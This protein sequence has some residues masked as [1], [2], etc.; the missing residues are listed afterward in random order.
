MRLVKRKM[1]HW[2][3]GYIFVAPTII[4][5]IVLNI[6]PIIQTVLLSFQESLGFNRY[7]FAGL[8]NFYSVLSDTD[9]WL[10]LKN[11]FVFALISVPVSIFLSLIFAWLL[12]K[13]IKGTSVYRMIFFLPLVA[14]P[15]AVTMVWSW[16]YNTEF[17]VLNYLLG[18]L[19]I[20][21]ISW[22]NDTRYTMLSLIIIAV[23]GSL[24]QQIIILIVAIK[25]VPKTYYEAAE[26]DG[27][28]DRRKFFNIMI[29]LVSPNIFFLTVT[30]LIGAL[31][32]FDL[33]YMIYGTGNSEALDSVKT[34]MYQY[35]RQSFVVQDKAYGS[36]IAVVTLIIILV[37]T[38]IQMKLQKK[39][40]FYE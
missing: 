37:L 33:V 11:T 10:G 21:K 8:D 4:G 19:G 9:V 39:V 14:A 20:P 40:V 2:A 5:L 32:Q 23:W 13:P 26:I 7:E 12:C 28:T 36:A 3:W 35:Y 30:G 17:G 27:A 6:W 34:I 31:G 1:K 25:N 24:G 38:A 15:A 18:F 29:P 16:I 22:L